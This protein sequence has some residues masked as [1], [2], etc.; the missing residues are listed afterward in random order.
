[1]ASGER[2]STHIEANL[3]VRGESAKSEV[4]CVRLASLEMSR[5]HKQQ[6]TVS[7]S[8]NQAPSTEGPRRFVVTRVVIMTMPCPGRWEKGARMAD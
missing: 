8:K 7:A 1:M 4:C 3:L 2:T 6:A 5:R